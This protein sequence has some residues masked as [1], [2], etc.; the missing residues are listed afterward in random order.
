MIPPS[1][2]PFLRKVRKQVRDLID[3]ELVPKRI[4]AFLYN[5]DSKIFGKKSLQVK[6]KVDY[7]EITEFN[8]G[9]NIKW[10]FPA[11]NRIRGWLYAGGLRQ[12]G[13]DLARA[14][15]INKID[16]N[17]ND[18][19][20]D[21]GANFGDFW[22]YLNELDQQL[23][24]LSVEPGTFEF[25]TLTR[26]LRLNASKISSISSNKALSESSGRSLF[27]YSPHGA[28]SSLIKP[29]NSS[30]SYEV[31]CINLE[32]LLIE[33]GLK[34]MPI[35][36]LKL[37]AQGC[38]PEVIKGAKTYLKNIEYIAADLGPERGEKKD[39][40]V[41]EVTNLLLESGFAIDSFQLLSRR[42]SVLYKRKSA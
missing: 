9:P 24:Y 41:A 23:K 30:I 38:E 8:K 31:E 2:K 25:K 21:C 34:N 18:L 40:T 36:L 39:N 28:D 26:N 32:D 33:V 37:E 1:I 27:Y 7:F 35:K 17:D 6:S 10:S 5:C 22:L 19:I 20:V 42:T 4:F 14:Y 16:L 29:S 3:N 13:A 12:R 15:G 11:S